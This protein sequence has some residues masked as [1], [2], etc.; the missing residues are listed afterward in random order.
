VRSFIGVSGM[1]AHLGKF[2]LPFS[3][4]KFQWKNNRQPL[5]G[6]DDLNAL[7]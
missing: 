3:S 6:V 5:G 4:Q 1:T 2:L 7:G